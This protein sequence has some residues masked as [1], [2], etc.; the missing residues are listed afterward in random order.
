MGGPLEEVELQISLHSRR[1]TSVPLP[2]HSVEFDV[3]VSVALVDVDS[4]SVV[5]VVSVWSIFLSFK[6][7]ITDGYGK[8]LNFQIPRTLT[9]SQDQADAQK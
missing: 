8:L 7:S 5:T 3:V 1:L 2:S 4:D 6:V 9:L